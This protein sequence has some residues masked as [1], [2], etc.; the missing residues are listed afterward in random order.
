MVPP[1]PFNYYI[2]LN[3]VPQYSS[4]EM[5]TEIVKEISTNVP[6]TYVYDAHVIL[7]QDVSDDYYSKLE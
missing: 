4:L 5:K 3:G 6:Y 2:T 1:V 7:K